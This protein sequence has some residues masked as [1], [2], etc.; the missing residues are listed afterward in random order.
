MDTSAFLAMLL[1]IAAVQFVGWAIPGPNHLAIVAAS[2]NGG[3]RA[4][5]LPRCLARFFACLA[6]WSPMK[7]P[8]SLS[9]AKTAQFDCKQS[10]LTL[11][12]RQG[13][14]LSSRNTKFRPNPLTLLLMRRK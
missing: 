6:R 1:S 7:P 3:R 5:L 14:R 12:I 9:A 11:L 2:V 10:G 13:E 8:S 4:G